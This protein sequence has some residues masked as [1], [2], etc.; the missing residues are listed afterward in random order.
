MKSITQVVEN[1][2]K[3]YIDNHDRT[4][5]AIIA[6]VET[7]ATSAS[8]DYTVGKQ[9]IL[10]NVL[11]DV[12]A[13]ITTGD[14]LVV[15]T[16]I[17]AADNVTTQ[18]S[19]LNQTLTNEVDAIVNVYGSKNILANNINSGTING[20]TITKNADKTLTVSGTASADVLAVFENHKF[21]TG[22]YILSGCPSGGSSSSGYS[23]VVDT[24][25]YDTGDGFEFSIPSETSLDVKLLI[26]SGTVITTPITF[27]PMIRDARIADSTY[28]PY[29][30]TNQELTPI[31]Q[32]VSNRNLLDNPWFTVNQRSF[33]SASGDGTSAYSTFTVDRWK[34]IVNE[35]RAGSIQ[36]NNDGTITVTSTSAV[37]YFAQEIERDNFSKFLDGKELTLSVMLSDG[38][39]LSGTKKLTLNSSASINI[40]TTDDWGARLFSN[41][42][43]RIQVAIDI[44]SSKSVTIK[45]VKLELGSVS[46]LAQDTA[47]NYQQELA[48]CQRYF[49]RI[50]TSNAGSPYGFG[51]TFSPTDHRITIPSIKGLRTNPSI[52]GDVSKWVIRTADGAHQGTPTAVSLTNFDTDNG[53]MLA[54][55]TNDFGSTTS[56]MVLATCGYADGYLDFS[57]DL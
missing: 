6:P 12:I 33:S 27:K 7:D 38:T 51:F 5:E 17:K 36:L 28:E 32:A 25:G 1:L 48:K 55:T 22:N 9:L 19:S 34:F 40:I 3:P 43:T 57:A 14:A 26:L 18:L 21:S 30:M 23:I 56:E 52:T 13:P 42:A 37:V 44:Y 35:N 54:F 20:I 2:I 45:A 15:N 29:S 53:V 49:Q 16:N 11:Y 31:A 4:A 39:I 46:T 41:S 50:K 10:N 24:K 8:D 47:P